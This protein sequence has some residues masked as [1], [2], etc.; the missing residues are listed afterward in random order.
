MS[1]MLQVE[2]IDGFLEV[3]FLEK[4]ILDESNIQQIGHELE[5]ALSGSKAPKLIIDFGNVEHLSSAALGILITTN[6]KVQELGGKM[7]LAN[8]QPAIFEIFKITRLDRVFMVHDSMV[9]AREGLG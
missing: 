1:T 2:K 6:K 5:A 9:A 4:N 7:S 3:S 8:I